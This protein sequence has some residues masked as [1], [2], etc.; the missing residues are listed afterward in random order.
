MYCQMIKKPLRT[1]LAGSVMTAL[2]AAGS[3]QA[4]TTFDVIGPHEYDLPVN[5]EPFNAFVQYAYLQDN[6]EAW[7]TDGDKYNL[8]PGSRAFVGLSKYV[9][10]FTVESLPNVG[11][12]FEVIQPTSSVRTDRMGAIDSNTSSGFGDT[13][14]GAAIWYKPSA[15]STLGVQ[16]FLQMPIGTDEASDTNW[17]NLTSV[18]WGWQFAEKWNWTGDAGFVFQ[19]PRDNRVH[20]GTSF[21]TNNRLSYAASKRFEPFI[22]LDYENTAKGN[23]FTK[24]RTLDA[25]FGVMVNTFSNQSLTFRYSK[26]VNGENTAIG[27]TLHVKYAYIW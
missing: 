9:R 13:M 17:K 16:T 6:S 2:L 18:L 26:G 19:S 22:G 27:D 21:H 14:I 8:S 1:L 5:Y 15:N 3:A 7:D 23:L 12:A 11:I 4:V 25:S 20:P 10:F 24:S